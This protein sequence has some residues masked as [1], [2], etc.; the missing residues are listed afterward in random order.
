M[1]LSSSLFCTLMVEV[2][3]Q[4]GH[5]FMNLMPIFTFC[6]LEKWVFFL[7]FIHK[8]HKTNPFQTDK[9]TSLPKSGHS[10]MTDA[11]CNTVPSTNASES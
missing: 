6:D 5:S 4:F 10:D 3:S 7:I 9:P 8:I 11:C 2:D 1:S